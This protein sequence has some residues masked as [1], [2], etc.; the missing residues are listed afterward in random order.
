MLTILVVNCGS[1]SLKY[2]LFKN[3]VELGTGLIEKIGFSQAIFTCI[4]K[5]CK[6]GPVKLKVDNHTQAIKLMM[7]E[8]VNRQIISSYKEIDAVGHRVVHGGPLYKDAALV[9]NQVLN[10]KVGRALA[11]LHQVNYVGI[12]ACLQLM[13]NTPQVAVFDTAFHQTMPPRAYTYALPHQLSEKYNIRK[14]GFHGSSHKFVVKQAAKLLNKTLKQTNVITLHL[15]NGS[16]IAAV[17]QGKCIDTSMGL[18]PL[19]GVVMGTRCGDIDPAIV[20]FLMEKEQLSAGQVEELLNKKSGVLGLSGIS[21]DMREIIS[22]A[23]SGNKRAGLT[24]DVFVYNIQKYIGAYQAVV[25]GAEAIIF[26]AGIGEKSALL[27]K[28]ICSGLE[29]I[30]I[31]LDNK[32]NQKAVSRE[33]LIHAPGSKVKIAVIP[34]N[35]E[36]MIAQETIRIIRKKK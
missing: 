28:M 36:L 19:A 14:Y 2:T 34:T 32:K 26:T 3:Q 21:N 33:M 4:C 24:L 8:L 23:K 6:Q 10:N 27:R 25:G 13:P 1:S 29:G 20:A 17:K 18:T 12:E 7:S 9:N 5:D 35:E 15:G 31:K 30:G 16:S 22:Q 11:P